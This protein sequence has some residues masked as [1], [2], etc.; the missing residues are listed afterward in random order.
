[1]S[2]K[3]I[4][5][6]ILCFASIIACYIGWINSYPIVY[7]DTGTYIDSGYRNYVPHDRTIFYGLFVRHISLSASLWFVILVQSFLVCYII[8][9]TLSLFFEGNK[10]NYL[11]ITLVLFLSITT[12][13]S[14]KISTIMPDVFSPICILCLINLLFNTK[15]NKWHMFFIS[16]LFVFSITTQ[17][18]SI[19]VFSLLFSVLAI[20]VLYKKIRKHP[21][22]IATK[23]LLLVF[24]LLI[25]SFVIVPFV[26][27]CF[28]GGFQYS[29]G[30]HVF[31]LNH[32][33]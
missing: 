23:K 6:F 13:L 12:G 27:F 29:K 14:L 31:M 8:Y 26:Q 9:T 18:S 19:V 20:W 28:G 10:K 3:A 22:G 21:I 15:L 7:P 33:L 4:S 24:S 11:F 25:A 30:S 5:F 17:L 2:S 1:M 16:V 32:L